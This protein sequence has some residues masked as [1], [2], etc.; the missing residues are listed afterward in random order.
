MNNRVV[1]YEKKGGGR[2]VDNS[3][4]EKLLIIIKE[5]TIPALGCTEPVA[6][7]YA[8]SVV[9]KYFEGE[10]DRLKIRTSKNIFKN[11]KSVIIP[12]T[13]EWGLDLAGVLGI[14]VGNPDDELMILKNIKDEHIRK[15][16]EILEQGIVDVDYLENTPDVYVEIYVQGE[17]RIVEVVLKDA[18]NHI[19]RVKVDGKVVYK[20]ML[21]QDKGLAPDFIKDLSFNDIIEIT[22]SMPIESIAF[23]EDGIRM[24]RKAAEMGIKI[25]NGL[26]IG[27]G[28]IKLERE[29]RLKIDGPTRARILTA[30]AADMRMGG[31]N[32]PIMT[33]SGSGNQGLGVVLPIIVVAEE[34]DISRERLIRAIFLAHIINKYVKLHTGKLSAMCGCAI[35][36]GVGA[37]GAIS[38][39]LGGSQEQIS[40]ASNNMLANLTGMICDGAKDTCAL[41]LS[42]SAE[43]A[44]IAAYLANENIIVKPNIGIIGNAVEETIK[45]LEILCK[46]G[47]SNADS[48]IVDI[49][50]ASDN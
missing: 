1:T 7:A 12:N 25:E 38:W 19:D 49:I 23:V 4:V 17:E 24:N 16:H 14:I 31:G 43:E 6:V 34:N 18:H 45:N 22:E 46:E 2:M 47:L 37:S 36:A 40:G 26:N 44:V 9:N 42:A 30:A 32:C 50:K 21:D 11:G 5:E 33:S 13:K 10:I 8:A 15:A 41:K 39:M 20:G 35:G 29:G 28:L 48:I 3:I 27:G